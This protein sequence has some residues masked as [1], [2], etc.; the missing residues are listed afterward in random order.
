MTINPRA[1]WFWV[2]IGSI[3]DL[4]GQYIQS[5][6]TPIAVGWQARWDTK[7]GNIAV[8]PDRSVVQ[9]AALNQTFGL[10]LFN[11]TRWIIPGTVTMA[12]AA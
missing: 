6:P 10:E 5:S 1:G 8:L 4:G 11:G 2:D 3:L 7:S 9:I 12:G